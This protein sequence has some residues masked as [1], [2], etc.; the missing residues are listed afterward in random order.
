MICV[1]ISE[2]DLDKCL[3]TLDK[4][5]MA[6]I[7][8]D[9]TGFDTETV[10]KV[11]SYSPQTVT[12]ATCRTGNNVSIQ[13]QYNKLA[14]AVRA[15]AHYIDIEL[16]AEE[17][18]RK[19]LIELAHSEERKVIVSYHNFDST[20]QMQEL[21]KIAEKC[22]QCGADVAKIVT[23]ANSDAD[24]A[25]VLSLYNSNRPLVAFTMGCKGKI[26]RIMAPFMGAAFT[27]A[28][29]D[30]GKETAPG[31]IR[32]SSMKKIMKLLENELNQENN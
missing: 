10:T 6:E 29:M 28:S 16:E 9:L 22:Y 4:V 20:P 17:D 7:R 19:A 1:A 11:F 30:D 31:Q 25:K 27:F 13:D 18:H 23:T 14:A 5:E 3:K 2:P 21:F 24:N 32:Y 12:I 26:S 15:G 8:I